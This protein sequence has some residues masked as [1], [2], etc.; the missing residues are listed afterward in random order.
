ME[1]AFA[2]LISVVQ[3]LKAEVLSVAEQTEEIAGISSP[4]HQQDVPNTCIYQRLDGI[5]HHRLV[6]DG[7]QMFIRYTGKGKQTAARSPRQNHTFQ[8]TPL[9]ESNMLADLH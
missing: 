9:T 7:Q 2:I 5:K 6:I 4:G 3:V 1:S 8:A